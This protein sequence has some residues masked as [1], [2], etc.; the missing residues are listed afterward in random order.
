VV[1]W[2][3]T[4]RAQERQ[5]A[6]TPHE[7]VAL[8]HLLHDMRLY[9]SR[10]EL[11]TMRRAAQI[12]TRAHLRAIRSCRPGLMEYQLEAEILH[13]FRAHNAETS[14]LPIVGGGRN[15]C[16]LHYRHNNCELKDGDLLLID[17]G[18]EFDCYASDITRTF[19]VNGRYSPEQRAIY[20]LVLQAQA[21][22]LARI[23]PGNH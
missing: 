23:R 13:E 16:V 9:K 20:E 18:C 15:A 8:D 22:A 2:V 21:A 1:G 7:F 12:A 14:Y 19:P 3:N 10:P 4:L 5:G 17:A 6:A 11:D